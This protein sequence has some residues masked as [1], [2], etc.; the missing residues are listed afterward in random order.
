MR[1]FSRPWICMRLLRSD[2]CICESA[3]WEVAIVVDGGRGTACV[4]S[5]V[6]HHMI[7]LS[8]RTSSRY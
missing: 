3:L 8:D 5:M 6:F 1:E 7:M 2:I 4:L